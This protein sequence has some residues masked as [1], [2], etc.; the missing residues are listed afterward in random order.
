MPTVIE[1]PSSRTVNYNN[2]S[3][4]AT[5][6]FIV[7]DCPTERDVYALF[8]LDGEP[9]TNLPNKFSLY[10]NLSDL[11]P[12]VSIVAMDFTL[13]RDPSVVAKWSVAVTYR[14]T[15]IGGSLTQ[16]SPNDSGYVAVRGSTESGLVDLWRTYSSDAEFSYWLNQKAPNGNPLFDVSNPQGD[17]GGLAIDVAG[18]PSRSLSMYESIV[19]DVTVGDLPNVRAI[20]DAVGSRNSTAFLGLPIGAVL[21]RG[22]RW[23]NI[24]PGKW[25]V[26]YDF[27]ADYFYH[28][29]Q[30][31]Q[32][33]RLG[34]PF[35]TVRSNAQYVNWVQPYLRLVDHRSLSPFL[36]ALP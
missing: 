29:V 20:R 8:S 9:P 13:S 6:T 32:T 28:M 34:N 16:L 5:R 10:P 36:T 12:K 11:E 14:E 21:F 2:G 33:D 4:V 25:Q 24:S 35:L 7:T 23:S 27:L 22:A 18:R 17:I 3:P 31:P 30:Q 1:P 26:S 15:S 19:V